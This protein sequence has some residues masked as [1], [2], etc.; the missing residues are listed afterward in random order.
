MQSFID[1]RSLHN[2]TP[3]KLAD[4]S[5]FSSVILESI[6]SVKDIKEEEIYIQDK[7]QPAQR[8]AVKKKHK[9][10][11]FLVSKP[12]GKDFSVHTDPTIR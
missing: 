4:P 8:K 3:I 12:K 9:T 10:K 5:P 11:S 7:K 2:F 1:A 6:S